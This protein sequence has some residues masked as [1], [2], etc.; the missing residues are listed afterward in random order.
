M[1]YN[2]KVQ[3]KCLIVI[4]LFLIEPIDHFVMKK[5]LFKKDNFDIVNMNAHYLQEVNSLLD[6]WDYIE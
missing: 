2:K 1:K 4:V 5:Y 3:F 6:I